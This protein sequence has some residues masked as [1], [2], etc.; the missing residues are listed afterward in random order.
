[1]LFRRR[2]PEGRWGRIRTA[3]WPRR[4][5]G[6]SIQYF[7]KRVLRLTASPHAIAAGVAAGVFA[8]WTPFL[9][10]HFVIAIVL[11]FLLAGNLVASAI[12]TGFGN[13]ITF[14]FIWGGTHKLGKFILGD[15]FHPSDGNVNLIQRFRHGDFDQL[16]EPFLKPMAIGAVPLGILCAVIFYIL[17]YWGVSVFQNRRKLLASRN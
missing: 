14:P 12:G 7:V 10:F 3:L 16:W 5:F 8:S 17:T 1:M 9:G 11:A 2:E 4:S 6:R 13:P 15:R